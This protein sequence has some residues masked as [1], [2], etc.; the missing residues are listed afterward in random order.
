MVRGGSFSSYSLKRQTTPISS[1][2][3]PIYTN[4]IIHC[5][6]KFFVFRVDNA[7]VIPYTDTE[8]LKERRPRK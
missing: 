5:I 1:L 8:I 6:Q 2:L 7:L 4:L 3:T